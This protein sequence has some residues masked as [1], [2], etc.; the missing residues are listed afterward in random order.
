MKADTHVSVRQ[1]VR[2]RLNT[3]HVGT[4]PVVM[5]RPCS[6]SGHGSH[7]VSGWYCRGVEWGTSS[8][9]FVPRAKLVDA[10]N[11]NKPWRHGGAPGISRRALDRRSGRKADVQLVGGSVT[12][13]KEG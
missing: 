7:V 11:T 5:G 3:L 12:A 8:G 2:A 1:Q 4:A 6:S 10:S 9:L 13:E